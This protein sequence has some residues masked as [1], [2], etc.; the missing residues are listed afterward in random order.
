MQCR[1]CATT[2]GGPGSISRMPTNHYALN[3]MEMISKA[4]CRT[5]MLEVQVTCVI[6]GKH[7]CPA[8][9]VTKIKE[10][11]T[12]CIQRSFVAMMGR[13]SNSK[14]KIS[15]SAKGTELSNDHLR[16]GSYLMLG[17]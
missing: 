7:R 8:D 15:E 3:V 6:G 17:D 13:K 9:H 14:V 4:V 1:T 2:H 16:F 12:K 10:S 11:G 5:N